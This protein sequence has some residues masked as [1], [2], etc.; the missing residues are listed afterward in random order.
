MATRWVLFGGHRRHVA[1]DERDDRQDGQKD[2]GETDPPVPDVGCE[3]DR[4]A[5]PCGCNRAKP[6]EV[7]PGTRSADLAVA[8]EVGAEALF[9]LAEEAG[10]HFVVVALL[11]NH[12][13]E[14]RMEVEGT[15]TV[16]AALEEVMAWGFVDVFR[17]HCKEAGQYTFW[18]YR[19][20]YP[21]ERNAGWRLDHLM[22]TA[23]LAR[24]STACYID[25]EPRA[26]KRPSDHTPV[27]AEF[28]L[29]FVKE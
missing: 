7:S 25:R 15:Q 16:H 21:L 5:N 17:Q 24:R 14:L 6:V 9:D 11:G 2:E 1:N 20:K 22:A 18:D 28:D 13:L 8:V 29:G 26:A 19:V 3:H 4:E 12:D 23:P 27:V 10:R